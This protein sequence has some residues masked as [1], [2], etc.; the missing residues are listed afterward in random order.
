MTHLLACWIEHSSLPPNM[1]LAMLGITYCAFRHLDW[2][3]LSV[4]QMFAAEIMR[5]EAESDD[6][7]VQE[8]VS[9]VSQKL[10]EIRAI[11]W[12]I[13][14]IK[15]M[16]RTS[17][18]LHKPLPWQYFFLFAACWTPWDGRLNQIIT[19]VSKSQQNHA[20]PIHHRNSQNLKARW[21]RSAVVHNFGSVTRPAG[22]SQIHVSDFNSLQEACQCF[23]QVHV[24]FRRICMIGTSL[25]LSRKL[26]TCWNKLRLGTPSFWEGPSNIH[27]VFLQWVT[28]SHKNK[29]WLLPS[30][31]DHRNN[32]PTQPTA[33]T[34]PWQ[35]PWGVVSSVCTGLLVRW[36]K[37]GA[38]AMGVCQTL[39]RFFVLWLSEQSRHT[40]TYCFE[41]QTSFETQGFWI[42]RLRGTCEAQKHTRSYK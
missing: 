13:K 4:K 33:W 29:I 1:Q 19:F 17:A 7:H 18:S 23:L 20:K 42:L 15:E 2:G 41:L 22:S 3:A 5:L 14:R 16:P 31:L 6:E 9:I 40:V 24:R 32:F 35:C 30:E 34:L 37:Y 11:Q 26:K 25:K 39:S 8:S 12:A 21:L 36:L 28:L 10:P 38:A 27:L